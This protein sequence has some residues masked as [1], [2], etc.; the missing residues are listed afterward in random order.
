M[1]KLLIKD[2][3]VLITVTG[4][5]TAWSAEDKHMGNVSPDEIMLCTGTA[6][7]HKSTYAVVMFNG[8]V[9]EILLSRVKIIE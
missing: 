8:L 9:V 1:R 6:E 7:K 5:T 2:E 4:Y 3:G